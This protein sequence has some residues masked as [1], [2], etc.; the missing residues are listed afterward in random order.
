MVDYNDS[1]R[2]FEISTP[3]ELYP[4]LIQW[5]PKAQGLSAEAWS[6][7]PH[8][9]TSLFLTE[10]WN[11]PDWYGK[12]YTGKNSAQTAAKAAAVR[13]ICSPHIEIFDKDTLSVSLP[14]LE[15]YHTWINGTATTG[16]FVDIHLSKPLWGNSSQCLTTN[17]NPTTVFITPSPNM[18]SVT[19]GLVLMGPVRPSGD[20]IGMVCSVDGRWNTAVHSLTQSPYYGLGNPGSPVT[21]TISSRNSDQYIVDGVLPVNSSD[22]TLIDADTEWLEGALGYN[23]PFHELAD[24]G[25]A[26]ITNARAETQTSAL[27]AFLMTV[28]TGIVNMT[29]ANV[30]SWSTTILSR[31][32][33][34]ISTAFADAMSRTG[35]AQ[36]A[37]TID[38][39]TDFAK[40]CMPITGSTHRHYRL[41]PGP[42]KDATG[43]FTNMMLNGSTNGK[44]PFHCIV[45][46]NLKPDTYFFTQL[47]YAYKA[48]RP[49]DFLSIAILLLYILIVVTHIFCLLV[50]RRSTTCWNT[51]EEL[52]LLAKS[53]APSYARSPYTLIDEQEH[54]ADRP[55]NNVPRSPSGSPQSSNSTI[56]QQSGEASYSIPP[57][58]L[59]NTSAGIQSFKTMGLRTRIRALC[60][61]RS[62]SKGMGIDEV[63]LGTLGRNIEGG[64]EIQ[65]LIEG[66]DACNDDFTRPREGVEYG[67]TTAAIR[68]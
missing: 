45:S 9:A 57:T 67:R 55:V 15:P 66:D 6:F 27:G 31:I 13:T 51:I 65:L 10:L 7:A 63:E 22:W 36:Q 18:S 56:S 40:E 11:D 64:E 2:G 28:G 16:D 35:Y 26:K 34:V 4:R 52:F 19:T 14:D 47:G 3:D 62:P 17:R 23:T 25:S 49:T 41:C 42:S 33:P 38:F 44:Q 61:Q 8:V 50:T 48:A 39:K 59:D 20:R 53:S 37:A 29:T 60:Q 68:P 30:E 24:P 46:L 5:T 43:N 58:A 32:E 54:Q 1:P 12:R 21:A